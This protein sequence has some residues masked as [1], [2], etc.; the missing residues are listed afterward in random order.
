MEIFS[1][2]DYLRNT[3]T[4]LLCVGKKQIDNWN[5]HCGKNIVASCD[6]VWTGLLVHEVG[7]TFAA[8]SGV[9]LLLGRFRKQ[10][11]HRIYLC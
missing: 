9:A 8:I 10:R 11:E 5:H 4:T 2:W 7:N 1:F 3:T 6:L